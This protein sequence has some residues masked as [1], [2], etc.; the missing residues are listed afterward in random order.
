MDTFH[1]IY[2]N[3]IQ[4][5]NLYINIV[6]FFLCPVC[7]VE[8]TLTHI[9]KF[10]LCIFFMVKHTATSVFYVNRVWEYK[11]SCILLQ[12]V[13][14]C[15]RVSVIHISKVPNVMQPHSKRS[16]HHQRFTIMRHWHI[17]IVNRPAFIIAFSKES[18]CILHLVLCIPL[19]GHI[20]GNRRM[21]DNLVNIIS[22][23]PAF[24]RLT[25]PTKRNTS[26]LVHNGCP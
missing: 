13:W 1:I 2:A 5:L 25:S 11:V 3:N 10:K 12:H 19:N 20:Q 7:R 6:C 24:L 4:C 9:F 26:P 22:I 21:Q 16:T 18:T 17:P 14:F 15:V 23:E 8:N